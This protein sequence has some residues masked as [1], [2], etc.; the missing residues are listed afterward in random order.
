MQEILSNQTDEIIKEVFQ[1]IDDTV[2]NKKHGREKEIEK[3]ISYV[4][5][6]INNNHELFLKNKLFELE[7]ELYEFRL[8][9]T[10]AL[11]NVEYKHSNEITDLNRHLKFPFKNSKSIKG[12]AYLIEDYFKKIDEKVCW[13]Y[14]SNFHK[15]FMGSFIKD[16]LSFEKDIYRYLL[17]EFDIGI[18]DVDFSKYT[19]D[20]LYRYGD[21]KEI[22]AEFNNILFNNLLF[23][24]NNLSYDDEKINFI[25]GKFAELLSCS[26]HK[27]TEKFFGF[28]KN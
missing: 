13:D 17:V 3:K 26:E 18:K 12:E 11:L 19:F 9:K 7:K 27:K 16:V 14:D 21:N 24:F 6:Y 20:N 23:N 8:A 10:S 1:A 28:L 25:M 2:K 22:V 15:S 4:I 5:T